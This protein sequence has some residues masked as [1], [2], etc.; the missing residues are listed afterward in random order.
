MLGAID[1]SRKA[2]LGAQPKKACRLGC[3][4]QSVSAGTI[5][6]GEPVSIIARNGSPSS[7]K[8]AHRAPP[9]PSVS[10]M[11]VTSSSPAAGTGPERNGA[12][13]GGGDA[14]CTGLA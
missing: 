3:A 2:E 12:P 9:P 8:A 6:K 7:K 1:V 14:S 10:E 5:K 13:L 4:E 11:T